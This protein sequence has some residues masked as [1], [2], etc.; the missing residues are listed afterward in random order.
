[1]FIRP[2]VIHDKVLCI[3]EVI[4]TGVMIILTYIFR[5]QRR[6]RKVSRLGQWR[7]VCHQFYMDAPKLQEVMFC[8]P[9]MTS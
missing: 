6:Q 3:N 8:L 1:M 9:A 7:R 5:M 2:C 4:F